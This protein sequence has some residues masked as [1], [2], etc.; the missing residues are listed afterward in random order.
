MTL[1]LGTALQNGT[2]VID[3]LSGEDSIGPLYLATHVSSGQWAL[4]RVLGSR[5]PETLPDSSQRNAFYQYLAALSQ[6]DQGLIPKNLRG[7]EEEKVCYQTFSPPQGSPLSQSITP[8]KPLALGPSLTLMQRLAQ[9]LQ[10]L[11]SLGWAGLRLTPDQVWQSG[12]GGILTLTGFDFPAPMSASVAVGSEEA[13]LVRGLTGLL[14]FLLTGQRANP[15]QA[16][17]GADLRH[18][19]PELPTSLDSLFQ[20]DQVSPA[21]PP[22]LDQWLA[23][24]SHPDHLGQ[25]PEK[26]AA[27]APTRRS[28]QAAQPASPQLGSAS[29]P[30]T[31][32]ATALAAPATQIMSPPFQPQPP[33]RGLK[34]IWALLATGFVFG[35]G[36]V[37]FGL[38]TR[39][40]SASPEAQTRFNPNQAFPPLPNWNTHSPEFANPTIEHRRPRPSNR[41]SNRP[42]AISPP[43]GP[44]PRPAVDN[45]AQPVPAAAP[46]PRSQPPQ[47]N[48]SPPHS[49]VK[50]DPP[51][52]VVSPGGPASLPRDLDPEVAPDPSPPPR[53]GVPSSASS[54]DPIAPAPMA[55]VPSAPAPTAPAPIAPA[56]APTAPA[57]IAPAPPAPVPIAPAPPPPPPVAPVPPGA[58][59][60]PLTSS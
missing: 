30:N 18:R 25:S 29:Q 15:T 46:T 20:W 48:P 1:A 7:F 45:S 56:P 33:R 27:P 40:H 23:G 14:Y 37:A 55:P 11:R 58:P 19:R 36:G 50:K 26:S 44:P 47:A 41:P 13:D 31:T 53:Q 21:D 51:S 32:V 17:L 24:L 35:V 54:P 22:S 52:R 3:A 9:D 43:A 6:L 8:Q 60:S 57:P 28:S 59:P 4:V 10:G 42:S 16:P 34:A 39:L 5:H 12:P 38:Q 2:Y 49:G